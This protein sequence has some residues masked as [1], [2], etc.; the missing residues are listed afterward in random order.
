MG[1]LDDLKAD[2][3]KPLYDRCPVGKFLRGLPDEERDE[4]LA[5]LDRDSGFS[6]ALVWKHLSEREPAIGRNAL[7]N[8]RRGVCRCGD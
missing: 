5:A 2:A 8:H 3:E 7:E 1:I 6:H 4:W